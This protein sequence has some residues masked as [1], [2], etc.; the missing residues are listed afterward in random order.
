IT[1]V[2][3]ALTLPPA[4]PLWRGL[5]A[6]PVATGVG[7]MAFG[8]LGQNPFNPALVGRAFLQAA[9]PTATTTWTKPGADFSQLAPAVLRGPFMSGGRVDAVTTATPLGLAKFE[10]ELAP[11]DRLLFGDTSGSLGETSAVLLLVIG[12]WLGARRVFDYR[13][14][15]GTLASA[16]VC[17]GVLH[18]TMPTRCPPPEFM[19]LSG[20]LLFAAVFMVTDPVTSPVTARGAWLF[21]AG[22]GLLVVLIRVFGGLPEGVMYAVLLM[23]AVT[24]LLDRYTQPK[25]FGAQVR[26]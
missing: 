8:G 16:A 26:S 18:A 21:G 17:S 12:V 22:V 15:V 19:L 3:L 7:K 25:P 20:G 6:G 10:H 14:A 9:F 24:P 23:N 1:G 13:L 4:L 5:L 11:L 2:L